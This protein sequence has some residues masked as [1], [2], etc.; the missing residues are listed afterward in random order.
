[1]RRIDFPTDDLRS[2]FIAHHSQTFDHRG[3]PTGLDMADIETRVQLREL[4]PDLG[5][6]SD[7]LIHIGFSGANILTGDGSRLFR[8]VF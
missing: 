3:R 2:A 4:V 1:M 7:L 8:L 6:P 5:D